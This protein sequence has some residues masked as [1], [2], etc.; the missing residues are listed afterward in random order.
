M[1]THAPRIALVPARRKPE[2]AFQAAFQ[3]QRRAASCVIVCAR[4]SNSAALQVH[5]RARAFG[6]MESLTR[7]NSGAPMSL[8]ECMAKT[9]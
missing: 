4:L 5:W 9:Q 8:T 7:Q 6:V 3:R 1:T 2:L